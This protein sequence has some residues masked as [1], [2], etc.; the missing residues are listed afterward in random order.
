MKITDIPQRSLSLVER[1]ALGMLLKERYCI[2]LVECHDSFCTEAEDVEDVNDSRVAELP[3][4][5]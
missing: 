2:F 1:N 4:D 5:K 3:P